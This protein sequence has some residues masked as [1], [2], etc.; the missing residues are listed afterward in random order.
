MATQFT[1]EERAHFESRLRP[2]AESGQTFY[3][4]TMAYLTAVKRT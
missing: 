2:L 4:D 3:R 1:A